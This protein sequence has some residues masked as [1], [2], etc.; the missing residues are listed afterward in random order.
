M[1]ST[2]HTVQAVQEALE[3]YIRTREEAERIR[4]VLAVN[5]RSSYENGPQTGLIALAEPDCTFKSTSDIRG[6]QREYLKALHANVKAQKEY[7]AVSQKHHQ[8]KN[9]DEV[10][11]SSSLNNADR[12]EEHVATI[13]LKRKQERLQTVEKYLELLN[14]KPAASPTFLQPDEIFKEAR[15]LPE[16]P[17]TVVDGFAVDKESA[18]TDL[19]ALVS[20]LER[21]VL[22]SKLLLKGE[23]QLLEE[24]KSR[25]TT[26]PEK[27][28]DG[29]KLAAL[30][31]TRDELISWMELEL[32]KASGGDDPQPDK[33][34]AD[35]KREGGVDKQ[36]MDEQLAQI[37]EKYANYVT[38]RKTL[39]QL[40]SES[41]QPIMKPPQ[42][43]KDKVR[44]QTATPA[45][46]SHLHTP[47]IEKLLILAQEHK[48]SIAQK[49]LL[50]DFL[51]KQAEEAIRTLDHLAEE[52]QLLPNHPVP[53][54]SKRDRGFG[55]G[56]SEKP[57]PSIAGRVQ[58]WVS[59][60][61]S[62]KLA[63]LVDVAEKIEGGQLALEG[64]TKYLAEINQLLGRDADQRDGSADED[65]MVD[66]IW[67]AGSQT[68]GKP[69]RAKSSSD[70]VKAKENIWSTLEGSLGLI[71][72]GDSPRK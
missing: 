39:L 19:K 56:P 64:S 49:T 69:T 63:T 33:G 60:A 14:Q 72:A 54:A 16:V 5:L 52:S 23:E 28:S 59:A 48:A 37:K 10:A 18:K 66:D 42:Q 55:E 21:A 44:S 17:K 38:A 27:V 41:P 47:Y 71:N 2:Q 61:D 24:V 30:G 29:A 6:L 45:P 57:S 22:R 43:N 34:A 58:P 4:R 9:E 40:V 65:T 67:L 35:G 32:G 68:P 62:A 8:A 12:L 1:S 11:G 13:K 36:L 7:Q 51:S 31:T 70:G 20:R 15:R 50:R 25:S 46:L 53:G 3:P 26:S